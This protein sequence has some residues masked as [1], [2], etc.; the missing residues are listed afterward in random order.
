MS[1]SFE[2]K[3]AIFK[4][5]RDSLLLPPESFAREKK[6]TDNLGH[7]TFYNFS[8]CYADIYGEKRFSH[9]IPV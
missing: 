3:I 6:E 2:T 7:I 5:S 8:V 9:Y 4:C 1:P